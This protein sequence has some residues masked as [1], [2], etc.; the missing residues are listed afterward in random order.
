MFVLVR[1]L[2][3]F[4][5]VILVSVDSFLFMI[6]TLEGGTIANLFL[7]AAAAAAC[8][9]QPAWISPDHLSVCLSV[10]L[11]LISPNQPRSSLCLSVY[12]SF[13][14]CQSGKLSLFSNNQEGGHY[15]QCFFKRLLLLRLAQI[16]LHELDQPASASVC[17][18][19]CPCKNA[20]YQYL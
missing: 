4:F 2:C 19:F 5:V 16:S 13:C 7:T 20:N 1:I 10:Y 14:P 9:D 17:V 12:V 18:S 3:P 15:R 11:C 6:N 8:P